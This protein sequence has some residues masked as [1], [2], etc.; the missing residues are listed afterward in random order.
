V[1]YPPGVTGNEY[2]ITG[3]THMKDRT[4]L[5]P[6]CGKDWLIELGHREHGFWVLCDNCQWTYDLRE[7]GDPLPEPEEV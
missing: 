7:Q 5:C 2:A 6:K 4:E 3:P 1:P